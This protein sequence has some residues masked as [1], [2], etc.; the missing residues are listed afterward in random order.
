[1]MGKWSMKRKCNN[2]GFTLVE[3]LIA[4]CILAIV[5]IPTLNY[6]ANSSKYNL[7]TGQIGRAHV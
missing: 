1:M 7:R 3:V 4:I 5:V 6:F 2:Q